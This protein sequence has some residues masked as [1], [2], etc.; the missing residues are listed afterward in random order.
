M[1]NPV[2]ARNV[3]VV[4]HLNESLYC[5]SQVGAWPLLKVDAHAARPLDLADLSASLCMCAFMALSARRSAPCWR[6]RAVRPEL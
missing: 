6:H 2:V 1:K 4:I 3:F 5:F